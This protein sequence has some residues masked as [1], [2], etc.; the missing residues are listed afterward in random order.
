MTH[1]VTANPEF[2]GFPDFRANVTF[3]PIQFF[4]VVIP[5]SSR[6]A[7]CI[8]GYVLRKLLGWVDDQ[9]NPTREQLRFTYQELVEQAGVS[10]GAVAGA[11]QEA[12]ANRFL[13]RLPAS[14]PQF[15][16]R[17]VE[18]AT[19]ALCWDPSDQHAHT[20][21][22]FR[23]FYYPDAMLL[24]EQDGT[25]VIRRPKASRKNIPNAF[26]DYL[27]PRER[28]SVIRVVGTLLFRSIQWGP[29]GERR[30]PVS[31]SITELSRLT[32]LS[33]QHV[34]AA[35]VEACHRGYLDPVDAGCFDPVA[36]QGS[37][38]ATYGIRWANGNGRMLVQPEAVSHAQ[39]RD[40]GAGEGC[41]FKKVNGTSI[42][43]GE[44]NQ[45]KIVNG[46]EYKKV[47]GINIKEELKT[48]HKT[49]AGKTP[50]AKGANF[51]V[52]AAAASYDLLIQAGFD[53]ATARLLTSR[54]DRD[55]I[56]RQID[57]LPLR[58]AAHNR[59]GLLRRSIEQDWPKP[60]G[61]VEDLGL[62]LGRTFASHYYAGYH[63][64]VGEAATEPFPK[65]IEMAAKFV[66]RLLTL[67][68]NE[69]MVPEWGRRFGR[70]MRDKHQG[71]LRAKPNLSMALVL[72]GDRFLRVLQGEISARQTEALG[73][74]RAAHQATFTPEYMQYLRQAEAE[75]QRTNPEL[76]E[77]FAEDR[78]QSRHSLSSSPFLTSAEW[79]ARFDSEKNRLLAFVDFF[80]KHA[81]H[82][83]LGFWEWDTQRNL[84]RFGSGNVADSG[85]QEAHA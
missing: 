31:C 79:L 24:E 32:R 85:T 46:G 4:T 53:P 9:G 60:E 7:I 59:L 77:A 40:E 2:P 34:H 18:G 15:E 57:W 3:T 37:R 65:D 83:V 38:A 68:R 66:A 69:A 28:R 35:V 49:T 29:G 30:V 5:N 52:P 47:N 74:A 10:R 20:L 41:Q 21:E 76:Y 78:R 84:H 42:Q 43:K 67:Q 27:L 58:G 39:T 13:C 6:G 61:A 25:R 82:P 50:V 17:Y 73:K 62:R 26:F 23:G 70:L 81:Q 14:S 36:G 33:R 16:H 71:D 1:E 63:A 19:Y 8:A 72:Y 12:V 55:V 64:Y 11:I 75:L 45:F 56:H 80:D 51:E 54:H 22:Q 44:R 48:E